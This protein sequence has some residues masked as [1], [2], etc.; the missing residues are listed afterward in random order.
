MF[1]HLHKPPKKDQQD[2][3]VDNTRTSS[4]QIFIL[5]PHYDGFGESENTE[6][7]KYCLGCLVVAKYSGG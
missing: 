7:A 5:Y 6:D 1:E 2:F 3:G 4:L